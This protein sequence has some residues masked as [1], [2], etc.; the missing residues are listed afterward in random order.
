MLPC[1]FRKAFQYGHTVLKIEECDGPPFASVAAYTGRRDLYGDA[2]P[3]IWVLVVSELFALSSSAGS[4][5]PLL[6]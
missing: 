3:M 2:L 5:R 4:T 6:S 1:T